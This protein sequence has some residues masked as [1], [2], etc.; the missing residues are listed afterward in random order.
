M[1]KT[2]ETNQEEDI[3]KEGNDYSN[4]KDFVCPTMTVPEKILHSSSAITDGKSVEDFIEERLNTIKELRKKGRKIAKNKGEDESIPKR[5]WFKNMMWWC[6]GADRDLLYVCPADHSKY[7]GIGTVILFTAIMAALSGGYAINMIATNNDGLSPWCLL[8]I[9]WGA[10]IFFLDRFITNTMYSDGK[11]TISWLEFRCALPRI[12]I[13]IFIGIVIATPLELKIFHDSITN[14]IGIQKNEEEKDYVE[15]KL[16]LLKQDYQAK[17]D[18]CSA[19]VDSL[20]KDINR[21]GEDI[22]TAQKNQKMSQKTITK[23]DGNGNPQTET[24][25]TFTNVQLIDDLKA[26]QKKYEGDKKIYSDSIEYYQ[27]HQEDN[28]K[29]EKIRLQNEFQSIFDQGLLRNI[30]TL[31]TIAMEGFDEKTISFDSSLSVSYSNEKGFVNGKNVTKPK[32][33]LES[34]SDLKLYII[35]AIFWLLISILT[36]LRKDLSTR[37]KIRKI[38]M[39]V[40]AIVVLFL[41]IQFVRSNVS[42]ARFFYF[43]TSPVGLIM[44]LFIII[45]VSPVFYKMMVADG[46]YDKI[47][48]KEKKIV[49]DRIR[50]DLVKTLYKIDN[51][52]VSEMSA[53][54]FGDSYKKMKTRKTEYVRMFE[55]KGEPPKDIVDLYAENEEIRKQVIEQKKN[56]IKTAYEAWMRKMKEVI[57]EGAKKFDDFGSENELV[58]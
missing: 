33:F 51:S 46:I 44:M 7:V 23:D 11:V 19:M 48:H 24:S 25:T 4:V 47:L 2:A 39:F 36:L 38:V 43:L 42:I 55:E 1:A 27:T 31:H 37:D 28:V 10:M 8:G 21:K 6:A 5:N 17:I 41:I 49:E 16:I 3:V 54:I 22:K 32:T 50:L 14:K 26:E 29:Q 45:D 30:R 57:S 34:L 9:V 58:K 20:T 12:I 52:D 15:K 18:R 35:P 53:F 13:S 40:L 56:V